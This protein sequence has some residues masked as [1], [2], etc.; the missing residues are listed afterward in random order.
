MSRAALLVAVPLPLVNTARYCLPLSEGDRTV[1]A[2]MF[3]VTPE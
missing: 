1:S 3:V 2:S